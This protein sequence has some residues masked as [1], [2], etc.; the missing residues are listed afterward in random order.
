M[1]QY[2]TIRFESDNG[3]ASLLLDQPPSNRMNMELFR[4]LDDLLPRIERSGD[5]KALIIYGNGRHFSSG[6]DLSSLL[7]EIEKNSPVTKVPEFLSRNYQALE[8][9]GRL[10]FPVIASIGGVCLGSAMELALT[11]HFRFCSSEAVFGLPESTFSLIPGLGGIRKAAAL[12]GKSR[13]MQ[14]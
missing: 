4:E 3:I 11:C 6:T 14:L 9:L 8:I 13:T 7:D 10:P 1:N 2:K 12:A 5:T